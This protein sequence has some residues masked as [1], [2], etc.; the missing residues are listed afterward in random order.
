MEK[1]RKEHG[2]FP[3]KYFNTSSSIQTILLVLELHQI[4]AFTLADFTANREFHPAL[5][6]FRYSNVV[7]SLR[8]YVGNVK[9]KIKRAAF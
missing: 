3:M 9:R 6:T 7:I 1:P 5:K 2:N 4:C 8:A